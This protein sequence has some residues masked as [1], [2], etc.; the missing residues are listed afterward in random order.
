MDDRSATR[1]CGGSGGGVEN[2]APRSREYHVSKF[3][4]WSRGMPGLAAQHVEAAG[5]DHG[6]AEEVGGRSPK[7]AQK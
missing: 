3:V 7:K 1:F 5:D 4:V 6:D 2:A